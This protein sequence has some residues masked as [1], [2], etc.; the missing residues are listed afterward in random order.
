MSF[1]RGDNVLADFHI[2]N[3]LPLKH[4]IAGKEL[5]GETENIHPL[6][7]WLIPLSFILHLY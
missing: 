7:F 2:C 6:T 5:K 3:S 4:L 1:L